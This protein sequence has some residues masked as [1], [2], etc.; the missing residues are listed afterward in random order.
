MN[1]E[2]T[3]DIELIKELMK[4]VLILSDNDG[5]FE[6][7]VDSLNG[8]VIVR[9]YD[10][11][12]GIVY[13]EQ[14]TTTTA[15][16]HPYLLGKKGNGRKMIKSVLK[17]LLNTKIYKVNIS[18]PMIYQS[19]INTAKKIGFIDEGINRQSFFKDGKYH[20]QQLFGLTRIEIEGLS[21]D[22]F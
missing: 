12:Q 14:Q 7:R 11:I 6:P 3:K 8:W 9:D 2:I 13:I 18:I 16:F 17:W 15:M 1:C 4:D 21:W 22:S 19:T 5:E 20:D 10:K